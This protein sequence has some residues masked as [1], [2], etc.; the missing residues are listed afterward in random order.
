[1]SARL[2]IIGLDGADGRLLDRATMDG[3]LPNLAALRGRG[4]GWP[5]VPARGETDDSLWASFQYG[6]ATGE[7]GRS[8]YFLE[9]DAGKG[10]YAPH[11]EN[12]RDTFWDKLSG[13]GHRVA[14]FDVPKCRLPRPLNGIHLADWLVHGR[15]FP[16]P[17]SYPEA[18]AEEVVA[19]FGAAPPSR[20]A[21]THHEPIDDEAVDKVHR[22]LLRSVEQ[23]RN[24]GVHFLSQEKWDLF[25][26]GFKEAHCCAHML[27]EFNDPGHVKY[28]AARVARLGNP[29]LE[30]LKAQD[31]A[32]GQLVA[33]ASGDAEIVVFSTSD[34]VPNGTLMHLMKPIA[35][36][37]NYVIAAEE[38]GRLV[39]S[40]RC[41]LGIPRNYCRSVFHS[42][43]AGALRVPRQ[44]S[45]TDASYTRRVELVVQ[46]ARELV[47]AHD[48]LP[49][50]SAVSYPAF[51]Q[52]G[53]RAL[54]L[55]QILLHYRVNICPSVVS[56]PR[57]GSISAGAPDIRTGNH[58]PGGFAFAAGGWAAFAAEHVRTM[59]DFASLAARVVTK[60]SMHLDVVHI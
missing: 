56:S 25:V 27:W 55:P 42:D 41:R 22:N 18:L 46:L 48:G 26:I 14:V 58:S 23:K 19:R 8:T 36:R 38:D 57:L 12:D 37:I 20:C 16:A 35:A 3:T 15:Y 47:D 24:A 9:D 60:E 45:D 52:T 30:V 10:R 17:S 13:Q 28:D 1:M 33:E 39:S 32:I 31:A 53:K 44:S 54:S 50:V 4:R 49:V 34:F 5:L 43:D 6:V 29:V 2:L 40:L 7:H 59:R 51:E 11:E 21:Y